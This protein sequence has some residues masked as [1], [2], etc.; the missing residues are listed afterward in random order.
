MPEHPRRERRFTK[1]CEYWEVRHV[2]LARR[3]RTC[4][5]NFWG[6]CTV[7]ESQERVLTHVLDRMRIW[8]CLYWCQSGNIESC[9]WAR[10]WGV[11][12]INYVKALLLDVRMG[13]L[14]WREDLIRHLYRVLKYLTILI[15]PFQS[16]SSITCVS[17]PCGGCSEAKPQKLDICS[18]KT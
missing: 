1:Q 15:F 7:A 9:Q 10:F 6:T 18:I 2:S 3:V 16:V 5:L 17:H 14:P 8:I 11:W 12:Q 4:D 13:W